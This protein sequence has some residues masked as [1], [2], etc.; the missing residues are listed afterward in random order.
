[1]ELYHEVIDTNKTHASRKCPAAI[2]HTNT[3]F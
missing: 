2:N 3:V 1:M